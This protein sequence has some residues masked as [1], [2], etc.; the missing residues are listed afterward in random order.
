MI[1]LTLICNLLQKGKR[2]DITGTILAST[3]VLFL[4]IHIGYNVDFRHHANLVFI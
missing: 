1:P 3:H 2:F 4:A